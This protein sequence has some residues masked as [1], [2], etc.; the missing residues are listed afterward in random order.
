MTKEDKMSVAEQAPASGRAS[1]WSAMKE[2]FNH[3]FEDERIF[4][5]MLLVPTIVVVLGLIGY[6][7]VTSV[8]YSMTDKAIGMDPSEIKFVG[9]D[10][11]R[12]LIDDRI[13]RKAL[14]NTFNFTVT[15]VL[16]KILL[17]LVMALTLNEIKRGK[18]FFRA[19]FLPP[20]S[21]CRRRA[22]PARC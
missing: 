10:N 15:A 11:F 18:R 14:V 19:L 2:W 1:A 5:Y 6:P 20:G 22:P 4:G 17:G 12:A 16:F 8:Y 3:R 21:S 7:F 9:L 13:Y